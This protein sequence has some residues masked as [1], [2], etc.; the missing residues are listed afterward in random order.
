MYI[1]CKRSICSIFIS[2]LLFVE[3][4]AFYGRGV[5]DDAGIVTQCTNTL[6]VLAAVQVLLSLWLFWEIKSKNWRLLLSVNFVWQVV[7]LM[8]YTKSF[9]LN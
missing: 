2:V 1:K 8:L 3:L 5:N 9:L 4:Q 6:V 7:L